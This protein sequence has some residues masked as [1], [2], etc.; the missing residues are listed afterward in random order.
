[1]ETGDASG[2]VCGMFKVDLLEGEYLGMMMKESE[3]SGAGD[4]VTRVEGEFSGD[5]ALSDA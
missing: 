3:L 4:G 5:P 2:F 1:M